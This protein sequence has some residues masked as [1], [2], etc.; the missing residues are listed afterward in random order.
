MKLFI[1]ARALGLISLTALLTVGSVGSTTPTGI[2]VAQL[3]EDIEQ[4]QKQI[5]YAQGQVRF[6]EGAIQQMSTHNSMPNI[7]GFSHLEKNAQN[8][9]INRLQNEL[10]GYE[11]LYRAAIADAHAT[12]ALEMTDV[13]A[14]DQIRHQVELNRQ[15]EKQ[16]MRFSPGATALDNLKEESRGLENILRRNGQPLFKGD[17]SCIRIIK[18]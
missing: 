16:L 4:G 1:T 6:L 2:T 8:A 17:R 13:I 12:G 18:Q 9:T 7:L 10:R 14:Y 3:F 15:L 11:K 5:E